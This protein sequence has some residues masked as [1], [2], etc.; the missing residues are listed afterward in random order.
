MAPNST[1]C[2]QRI[3]RSSAYGSIGRNLS[4]RGQT[5][6]KTVR[7][8]PTRSKA[9]ES[10]S[11]RL[12]C[13]LQ[14]AN[15]RSGKGSCDLRSDIERLTLVKIVQAARC[16]A[17]NHRNSR[18]ESVSVSRIALLHFAVYILPFSIFYAARVDQSRRDELGKLFRERCYQHL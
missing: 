7:Q 16:N 18:I 15:C 5:T 2:R 4:G 12:K 10:Q 11:K 14:N 6:L 8:L 13:R 9:H 1:S 3:S 17:R